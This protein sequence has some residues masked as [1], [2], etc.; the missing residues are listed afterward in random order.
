MLTNRYL[1]IARNDLEA[2]LMGPS[3][4]TGKQAKINPMGRVAKPAQSAEA[5]GAKPAKK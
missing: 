5:I 4:Q 2:W 3:S 1:V